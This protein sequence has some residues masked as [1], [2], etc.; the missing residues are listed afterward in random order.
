MIKPGS[1]RLAQPQQGR[2]FGLAT[3]QRAYQAGHAAIRLAMRFSLGPV[4]D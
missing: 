1:H 4:H 2:Q 3:N